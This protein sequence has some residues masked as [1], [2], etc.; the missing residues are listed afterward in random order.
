MRGRVS[1]INQIF[2][3]SSNELGGL[4]AGLMAAW[5]GPV[6]ATVIG[7][8]VTV[9]VSRP[10]ARFWPQIVHVPALSRINPENTDPLTANQLN[11]RLPED[12]IEYRLPSDGPRLLDR[13]HARRSCSGKGEAGD[14]RSF[15][16]RH[17]RKRPNSIQEPGIARFD[18]VQQTDDPTR[19]VLVEVYRDADAP[20]RHKETAH[21][22]TWRDTVTP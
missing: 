10:V 22:Q 4:R 8:F 13:P 16:R 2:I 3:G 6:A 20:A 19:F 18:V 12:P 5:L 7:G 11:T 15:P 21:Y 9:S 14:G 17:G 1:A